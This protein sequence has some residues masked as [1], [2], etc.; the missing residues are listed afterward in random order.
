MSIFESI[1]LKKLSKILMLNQRSFQ[2]LYES[3]VNPPQDFSLDLY[4]YY[5]ALKK[6]LRLNVLKQAL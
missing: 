2:K 1:L 5:L 4:A 3:W 6:G